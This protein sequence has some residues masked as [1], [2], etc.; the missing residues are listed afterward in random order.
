MQIRLNRWT[1]DSKTSKVVTTKL[2]ILIV[3][4]ISHLETII[5]LVISSLSGSMSIS[6]HFYRKGRRVLDKNPTSN[7]KLIGISVHLL[8]KMVCW[9]KPH[10]ICSTQENLSHANSSSFRESC[11]RGWISMEFRVPWLS[12]F[13]KL[14][15]A[16]IY[17][18]LIK[19]M[20]SG[21]NYWHPGL[22][23]LVD[24]AGHKWHL[25]T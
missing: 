13:I 18:V 22:L 14:H 20:P 1:G 11:E 10:D 5:P 17:N 24:P 6:V 15:R 7:T 21:L 25:A 2:S 9:G 4:Q 8:S 16:K 23:S 19:Y 3:C 12:T